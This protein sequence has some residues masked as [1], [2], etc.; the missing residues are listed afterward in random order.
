M[1][2]STKL[3]A[4]VVRSVAGSAYDLFNWIQPVIGIPQNGM[5]FT[6][7]DMDY[8]VMPTINCAVM[9]GGGFWFNKCGAIATTSAVPVWYNAGDSTWQGIKNS[10]LMVKL[11]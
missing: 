7:W 5:K 4:D 10:H 3:A 2:F 6:T 9:F 1:L 11:Q 8:D